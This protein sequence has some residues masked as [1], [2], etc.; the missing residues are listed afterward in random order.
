MLLASLP[1][2]GALP[3][4]AQSFRATTGR[5]HP[6]IEWRVAETE[7]FE[8][9]YPR[10]LAGIEARAAPIAEESYDAL[11]ENLGI[12][13]EE[14]FTIYLSDQDEIANGFAVP[15]G[16]G[17]T[18][19]W[20]HVNGFAPT[21]TGR[22]KWLRKVI[23]HEL[24]HLFHFRAVESDLGLAG[25]PLATPSFWTEGLAQY[26]T[27]QWDAQRGDR[28]LR[29]AVLADEL[30][31]T[32]GQSLRNGR[33][34][35]AVGNSQV[36]YLAATRGDSTIRKVLAHRDTT[37]PLKTYTFQ[38]AFEEVT[39]EDYEAFYE[40]WRRHVNVYYNSLAG[41]LPTADSLVADSAAAP[42]ER[43]PGQYLYDLQPA[44]GTAAADSGRV[45]VLSVISPTR[46]LRRLYVLDRATGEAEPVAEGA[47]EAPVSWSRDGDSLFFARTTRGAN[48]SL[49]NDLFAVGAGGDIGDAERLT[50]SRRAAS[51]APRPGRPSQIAFVGA[52][53][54]AAN[55]FLLNRR[56]GE[57]RQLTHFT[58]DV[59]ISALAWRP[60]DTDGNAGGLS[61][62]LA[63]ARFTDAGM[64]DIALLDVE[65]GRVTSITAPR[66]KEGADRSSPRGGSTPRGAPGADNRV[67]V[68][69]P[70]G[71]RLAY[72]TLRDDVPNI[73]TYDLVTGTHRRVT[74]LAEGATAY[75]WLAPDSTHPR[76]R[77]A[78]VTA[79]GKA[80]D[81]ALLL[82]AGHA[83]PDPDTGA[84]APPGFSE[85]TTTRPPQEVPTQIAPDASLIEPG[86][87][88]AYSA[89]DNLTHVIS[90]GFPYYAGARGYGVAAGSV[91]YEPLGTHAFFGGG[92]LAVN[93][94]SESF[95][96]GEYRNNQFRP[97]L[98]LTAERL[99]REP[100]S[101]GRSGS[102]L[103]ETTSALQLEADWAVDMWPRPYTET[104]LETELELA[105]YRLRDTAGL[106]LA[107]TGL[108]APE[109]GQ[110]LR[111]EVALERKRLPPYARNLVHP[112]DGHGW[113]LQLSGAPA[114]LGTDS[115]FLR[116]GAAGFRLLPGLFGQHRLYLYGHA[117]AQ[118]GT[119]LAQRFLGL[120]RTDTEDL[121]LPPF[122]Y[123]SVPDNERVRGYRSYAPGNRVAFGTA[124]Y[125]VPVVS[126]LRTEIL[127]LARLGAT[128]AALFADSGL[129]WDGATPTA[130]RLGL[131]VELKN[132]VVLGGGL[133]RVGH[134]LGV[135]QPADRVGTY[136]E[137]GADYR[138]Y[139][140]VQAAVPF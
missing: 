98:S 17:Y 124:E 12:A 105:D 90:G 61:D 127:G 107:G 6:E 139:Y 59:Q 120:R 62:T 130:R 4:Q 101:Y 86:S 40:D 67:P 10:R 69:A 7:H 122:F 52:K 83:A 31:Y 82:N 71:D 102:S 14:K 65:S 43:A 111:F 56:T 129:V 109:E 66:P 19:I 104:R 51:P 95:F 85:W 76:G 48:G 81:R 74:N 113:R 37:G 8:I 49:V 77:L 79:E 28:W 18:Q 99:P 25:I 50:R 44:P 118:T 64:R 72:T 27:E 80:R 11:S 97:A 88:R 30:S 138:V 93:D 106:D 117:Q 128:S 2:L 96:Y 114:L 16:G 131:G 125:R 133:L 70:G 42:M 119:P 23:A 21:W 89:W 135:A 68:F 22:A 137:R 38:G 110:E 115:Q 78:A 140:R 123:L 91:W 87:R 134:A 92:G 36:R 136:D 32:D 3:A 94:P 108:P 9:V 60:G 75:G 45:A 121:R 13:P 116:L 58:G 100:Q 41:Q 46:P 73:F 126:G 5:N 132:E 54:S 47:I 26:E 24:A 57:E 103:E 53:G 34:R 20:V 15:L 33:L 1:A 35:Y 39:G 29:T 55:L 112:L 63:F 84:S